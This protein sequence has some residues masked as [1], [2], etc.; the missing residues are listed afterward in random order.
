M[1]TLCENLKTINKRLKSIPVIH[2]DLLDILLQME[3]LM[4]TGSSNHVKHQ[5]EI[6]LG[7]RLWYVSY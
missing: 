6:F 4:L 3:W 2:I 7:L 5:S 1:F